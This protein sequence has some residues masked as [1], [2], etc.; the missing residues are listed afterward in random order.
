MA[1]GDFT[2]KRGDRRPRFR[3]QLTSGKVNP[4]A[5]NLTG[6]TGVWF[7]MKNVGGTVV[8]NTAMTIID[9]VNG[10]VEYPWG[11][12]DTT[13]AGTFQAEV[14]VAWQAA[15]VETQTFP[16]EGTWPVVITQDLA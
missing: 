7:I 8:V 2:I 3:V 4:V 11:A 12:A 9:P 13:T 6:N 1:D 15:R 14:E 10:I 5:V 16:S